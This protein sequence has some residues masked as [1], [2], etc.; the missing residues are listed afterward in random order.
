M[1][2]PSV[3]DGLVAQVRPEAFSVQNR[4]VVEVE[5]A[6]VGDFPVRPVNGLLSREITICQTEMIEH[7]PVA[8]QVTVEIFCALA[9][10]TDKY[11]TSVF[12]DR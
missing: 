12:Q 4:Q 6:V 5:V 2:T 7:L 8:A 11:E 1:R 3:I 10:E 9:V